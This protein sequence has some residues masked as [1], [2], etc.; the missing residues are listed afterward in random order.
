MKAINDSDDS[1]DIRLENNYTRLERQPLN[2][3]LQPGAFTSFEIRQISGFNRTNF[4]KYEE[5]RDIC[6]KRSLSPECQCLMYFISCV[7]ARSYD[8][9]VYTLTQIVLLLKE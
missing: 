8:E 4:D 7:K 9:L 1:E 6:I 2:K 3:Y 5:R